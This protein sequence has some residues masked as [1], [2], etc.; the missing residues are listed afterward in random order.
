[1]DWNVVSAIAD[2]IGVIC[3]IAT[4]FY[5]AV[6]IRQNTAS[7]R[8]NTE[9]ESSRQWAEIHSRMA[10]SDYMVEIWD[11]GLTNEENLTPNEKRKFIWF[12]AEFFV[13]TESHYRQW[14]KGYLSNDS[15]DVYKNTAAGLLGNPL[16]KRWWA[17]GV[18]PYSKDF[19][20]S[21]DKAVI[22][23]GNKVWNYTP[24][25]DI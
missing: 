22:E 17:S 18:S 13:M 8:A 15:W 16:V 24:L 12:I 25:S 4:L 1:M 11:K 21:I 14:Q 9:L 19:K 2:I 10:H 3:L 23:L 20:K 6:Q 7:V 5:L